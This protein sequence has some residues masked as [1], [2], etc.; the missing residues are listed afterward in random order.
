ME[1]H[2]SSRYTLRSVVYPVDDDILSWEDYEDEQ[3]DDDDEDN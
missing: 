1:K 3:D 2:N